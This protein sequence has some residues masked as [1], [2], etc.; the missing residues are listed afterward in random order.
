MLGKAT[1]IGLGI[2]RSKLELCPFQ[3]QTSLGGASDRSNFMTRERLSM[4]MKPDHVTDS[5]R[6]GMN[7]VVTVAELYDVLVGGAMLYPIG[8]QM[9][10]WTETTTYRLGWQFGDGRMNQVPMRF[11]YRVR[12]RGSPLEVLASVVGFSGFVTWPGDCWRATF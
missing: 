8:F 12:P 2:R 3:I 4:Q 11:I 5:F 6:L 10:Y 1:C 7:V 9:D